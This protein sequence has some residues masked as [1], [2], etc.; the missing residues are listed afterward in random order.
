[1]IRALIRVVGQAGP[2]PG[3]AGVCWSCLVIRR[4]R[5]ATPDA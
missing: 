1:V 3:R 2:A 5:S 4:P